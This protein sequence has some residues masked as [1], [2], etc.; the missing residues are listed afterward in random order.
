MHIWIYVTAI[1][2][3][4]LCSAYFSGTETAFTSVNRI[5]IKNYASEG[6]KKAKR[7]LELTEDFDSLLTAILIGN[8]IVN[9]LT[10]VLATLLF[11]ELCGS[12]GPTIATIVTAVIVLIFGE[13]TPK[14][15]AKETSESFSMAVSKSIKI[16]M[17]ILKPLTAA[18]GAWKRLMTRIFTINKS[19]GV[20]EEELL[21]MV[22]EA[23][24]EGQIDEE[25]SELIQNAIEFRDLEAYDCIR[26]RIDVIAIE[27]NESKDEILKVFRETGFSRLPVYDDDIDNIL[28]VLNQKDFHNHIYGTSAQISEY[29][30]PV[31]F[32]PETMKLPVLLKKMQ[33]EH[34]HMAVIIDEYGGM[35]GIVT[36]ED[37]VEELVGEIYDEH[38]TVI[39]QEIIPLYDGS[40]R[41]KANIDVENMFDFFDLDEEMDVNT[42]NGWVVMNLDKLPETGD[43]FNA[44]Y[45]NKEF[46]VKVTKADERK[47]L[48]INLK[49]ETL[50]EEEE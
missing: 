27:E 32:A 50:P 47:A 29:I 30:S 4:V 38:D 48:E 11:V 44:V 34:T 8:N 19:E 24:T 5:R 26:P 39:S 49:V 22:E 28:G 35:S 13:I 17:I 21:T 2:L 37:I 7:V 40:Y 9:I 14:S 3:L 16:V 1:I 25:Q 23:E 12:I 36:M 10:T 41:V 46:D 33:N 45:G 31:V 42:V 43:T 6:N 20:T 15:L 18:F